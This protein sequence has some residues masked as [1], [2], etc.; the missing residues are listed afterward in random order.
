MKLL[1]ADLGDRQDYTAISLLDVAEYYQKRKDVLPGSDMDFL[2]GD[3]KVYDVILRFLERMPLGSGY[4]AVVARIKEIMQNPKLA[5]DKITLL[6]DS[7]GAGIPVIQYLREE[8][9]KPV[10]ISITAGS[11]VSL[12]DLGF[13]VPKTELV[14]ALQ[15]LFQSRR[16]KIPNDL[17]LKDEFVEEL[18]NFRVKISEKANELYEAG[19]GYH[20]DLVMSVALGAWYL[21]RTKKNRVKVRN[22]T[23][24]KEISSQR[25]GGSVQDRFRSIGGR[26]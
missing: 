2:E 12:H 22:K 11:N 8:G 21:T 23:F 25:F 6:I 26:M 19:S 1:C 20:D 18:Q 10:G 7:T 5:T 3:E 16:L 13:T 9:L 15:I 24:Q 14:S 4:P 17:P